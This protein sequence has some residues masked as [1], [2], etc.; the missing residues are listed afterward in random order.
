MIVRNTKRLLKSYMTLVKL[1]Y[2]KVKDE[3]AVTVIEDEIKSMKN[4]EQILNI[5]EAN[6]RS[7]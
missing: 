5:K 6:I 4:K 3:D 2:D 7:Y 1:S